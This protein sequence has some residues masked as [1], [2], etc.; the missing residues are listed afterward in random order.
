M[1]AFN[2]QFLERIK[3]SPRILIIF[4]D[5]CI[6]MEARRMLSKY[7]DQDFSYTDAVCFAIM[8]RHKIIKAFS[9]YKHFLIAGFDKIPSIPHLEAKQ[10]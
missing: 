8:K 3:S 4:S 2:V 6:E 1:G 10:P 7:D 5:E 9:F